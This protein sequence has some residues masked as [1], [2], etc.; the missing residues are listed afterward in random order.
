MAEVRLSPRARLDYQAISFAMRSR[1]PASAS[2]FFLRLQE[3]FDRIESYPLSGRVVP[4]YGRTDL[5]EVIIQSY[6]A[7]YQIRGEVL[8][9][10]AVH[11][12]RRSLVRRLG[13]SPWEET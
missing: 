9:I 11:D 3:A 8:L 7:V 6:R 1:S 4:E 5:R 12:G 2:A 13:A 10:L